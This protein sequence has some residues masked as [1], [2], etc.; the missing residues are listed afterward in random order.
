MSTLVAFDADGSSSPVDTNPTLLLEFLDGGIWYAYAD[1]ANLAG[2]E[3]L[4]LSAYSRVNED[5]DL[6]LAG[7][8]TINGAAPTDPDIAEVGPIFS[9]ELLSLWAELS[10]G[11]P[12]S[13]PWKVEQVGR[14]R[15]VAQGRITGTA[16]QQNLGS[17]TPYGGR[18]YLI[19]DVANM[20][21]GDDLKLRLKTA[22][23]GP[24][25]AV[26]I[27]KYK[28]LEDVQATQIYVLGPC[29][30]RDSVLP[31]LQQTVGTGRVY[32]WK[33]IRGE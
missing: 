3:N 13:L 31:T 21:A 14:L 6:R 27:A 18:F 12:R 9:S 25:G 16:G 4:T 30:A 32:D 2:G 33:L 26:R 24:G 22:A 1:G 28:L 7:A 15:V 19:V 5:S 29:L 8:M 17:T 11:G 23:S 10:S 20:Q